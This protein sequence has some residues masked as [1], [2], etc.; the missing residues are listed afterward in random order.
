MVRRSFQLLV[1]PEND[2][3]LQI[4]HQRPMSPIPQPSLDDSTYWGVQCCLQDLEVKWSWRQI[5]G[6]TQGDS[7]NNSVKITWV[8]GLPNRIHTK[9]GPC[10]LIGI[11]HRHHLNYIVSQELER[12]PWDGAERGSQDLD[13]KLP[14]LQL[15]TGVYYKTPNKS[16]LSQSGLCETVGMCFKHLVALK[17]TKPDFFAPSTRKCPPHPETPDRWVHRQKH[18]ESIKGQR[19]IKRQRDW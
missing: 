13:L 6:Y 1:P 14:A 9:L 5:I 3:D 15:A 2:S 16:S 10:H 17:A 12:E 11:Q 4:P 8:W 7:S 18:I 19:E